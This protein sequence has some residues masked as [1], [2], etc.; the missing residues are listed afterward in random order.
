MGPGRC[1]GGAGQTSGPTKTYQDAD[2][3]LP[4]AEQIEAHRNV[5]DDAISTLLD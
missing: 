4:E 3:T 1:E 5:Q 2:P